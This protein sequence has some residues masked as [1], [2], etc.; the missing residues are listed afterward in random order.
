MIVIVIFI[1]LIISVGL[2]FLSLRHELKKTRHEEKVT[3]DL[4]K[5]KVLFYAPSSEDSESDKL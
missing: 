5:G 2:S 3:Q 4:A 1:L